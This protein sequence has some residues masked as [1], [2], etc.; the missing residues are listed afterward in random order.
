MLHTVLGYIL[1]RVH[2]REES[3]QLL[4]ALSKM[5]EFTYHPYVLIR[6]YRHFTFVALIGPRQIMCVSHNISIIGF[7]DSA[8]ARRM[9]TP[10]SPAANCQKQICHPS[11]VSCYSTTVSHSQ[12]NIF[13]KGCYCFPV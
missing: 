10:I 12:T 5:C 7:G 3:V 1:S 8:Q 4:Y 9:D 2:N 13:A 11:K 6:P